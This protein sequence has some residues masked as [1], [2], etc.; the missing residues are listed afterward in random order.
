M[1]IK[2]IDVNHRMPG[3]IINVPIQGIDE[4][5]RY[6]SIENEQLALSSNVLHPVQPAPMDDDLADDNPSNSRLHHTFGYHASI[7]I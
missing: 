4:N 7:Q 1:P 5:H 2:I 6:D 3:S